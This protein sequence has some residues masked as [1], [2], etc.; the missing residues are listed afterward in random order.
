MKQTQNEKN[1]ITKN[2]LLLLGFAFLVFSLLQME[3]V[4]QRLFDSVERARHVLNSMLPPTL[5]EPRSV[6]SAAIESIQVAII[7]T[8]FGIIFSIILAVFA[9]KNLT[10]HIL[11][12]YSIKAFA[13]FV[14]AVPALIWALLFI[15]AVGLGPI[16]GIL[17]L[18]VNSIGMLLKVYAEAIEE[19]DKGVIEAIQA[20]GGSRVHVI[21]QGVI[22]SIMSIFVTWS[23][24]RLDINIR[25][26]A[27]LGIVGAGGIGY[28]LMRASRLADYGQALGVT[29]VIFLMIISLEYITRF[30]K[31]RFDAVTMKATQ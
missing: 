2:I 7:G 18:A 26:S 17:A 24:F 5:D 15:V 25:Y 8:L 9:A 4:P 28:E 29:F 30:I 22:P 12:S 6:F 23:V 21:M 3:L 11:I 13:G 27:V 14:R 1:K 20:T 19:I 10:P 31:N 16:P